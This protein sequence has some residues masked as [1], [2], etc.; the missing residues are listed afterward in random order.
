MTSRLETPPALHA[1][2]HSCGVA[3]PRPKMA[4][5][6]IRLIGGAWLRAQSMAPFG[7]ESLHD[8]SANEKISK[9]VNW[10][11]MHHLSM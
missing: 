5:D 4:E 7:Q 8:W 3:G 6:I 10:E 9:I 11:K 1:E 2:V